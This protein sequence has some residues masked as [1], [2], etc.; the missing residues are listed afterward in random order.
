MSEKKHYDY[1]EKNK[2]Y[3]EKNKEKIK[4]WREKNKEYLNEYSRIKI[5]EWREKNKEKDIL[6]RQEYRK[7]NKEKL[8]KYINEYIKKRMKIDMSFKLSYSIRARVRRALKHTYKSHK[9]VDLLGCSIEFLKEYL[10][11]KFQK[12]MTWENYGLY[13]WHIDHIKPCSKFNLTMES[14]QKM[15]FHY[16]NLQPLW[17]EDNLKKYNKM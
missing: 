14:E 2:E 15:C 8:K 16:T 11:S 12:G 5:K 9:T 13:G 3:R 7:N 10:E 6:A 4:E 1:R 17:A